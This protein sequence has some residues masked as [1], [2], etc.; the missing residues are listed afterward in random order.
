MLRKHWKS[1][2]WASIIFLAFSIPGNQVPKVS[3]FRVPHFDKFIHFSSILILSLLLISEF[4]GLKHELRIQS[5]AILW[6][7]LFSVGYGMLLEIL[8][9]LVFSYRSAS[10]WDALANILGAITAAFVYKALNRLTKGRF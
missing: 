1:L 8:Q 9:Y 10:Y 2:V 6:A 4:N 7:I 3:I 5:R